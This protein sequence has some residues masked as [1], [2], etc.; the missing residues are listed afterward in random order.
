MCQAILAE[1]LPQ[2]HDVGSQRRGQVERRGEQ[3][4]QELLVQRRRL[5]LTAGADPG[6]LGGGPARQGV[7]PA[8][9]AVGG[10]QL[11]VAGQLDD[12][13]GGH[14][15]RGVLEGADH[16]TLPGLC[17]GRVRSGSGRSGPG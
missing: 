2:G 12:H 16:S 6:D 11:A 10:E 8:G 5:V 1:R 14:A 3:R 4:L 15:Q 9:V 17:G 13:R 7:N